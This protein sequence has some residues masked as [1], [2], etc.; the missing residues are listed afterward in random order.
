MFAEEVGGVEQQETGCLDVVADAASAKQES[1]PREQEE[2]DEPE[3]GPHDMEEEAI[4]SP[5]SEE[6]GEAPQGFVEV[7]QTPEHLT[8]EGMPR[9]DS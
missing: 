9:Q 2:G 1:Q 4:V 5:D 7:G 6:G 3:E 8:E